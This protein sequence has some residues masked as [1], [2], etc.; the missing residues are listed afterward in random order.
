M[1]G[2]WNQPG[3][4][5]TPAELA[6]WADG[7]LGPL[8][9]ERVE[10]WLADHPDAAGEADSLRHLVRLYREHPAPEPAG[11]AWQAALGR[12]EAGLAARPA[13]TPAPRP[14]WRWR[15]LAGLVAAAAIGGVLLAR[16]L[17][18]APQAEPGP[19]EV[20]PVALAPAEDEEPFPVATAGEV[21]IIGMDPNDADRVLVGVPLMPASIELVGMEEVQIVGVEPDPEE[22]R[23]PHVGGSAGGPMIIVARAGED[24]KP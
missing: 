5:P 19:V 4:R 16:A 8:D 12:I 17:W 10:R 6:A 3:R 13:P 23:M 22:G 24:E 15:L 11:P 18:P 9:A 2:K 7:E 21:N 1:N 20:G 14:G